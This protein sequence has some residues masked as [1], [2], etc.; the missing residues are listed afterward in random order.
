MEVALSC[1][2]QT[3]LSPRRRAAVEIESSWRQT[4][5]QSEGWAVLRAVLRAVSGESTAGG[6]PRRMSQRLMCALTQLGERASEDRMSTGLV[7]ALRPRAELHRCGAGGRPLSRHPCSCPC[8][9][10][11]RKLRLCRPNH[12]RL[13]RRRADTAAAPCA[14]ELASCLHLSWN[15][16]ELLSAFFAASTPFASGRFAAPGC[17]QA[18]RIFGGKTPAW[19]WE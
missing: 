5:G 12:C 17:R 15:P 18:P 19:R 16:F 14:R 3:L 8:K 7:L 6:Q 2:P 4:E 10:H 11:H 1:A 9:L 13:G